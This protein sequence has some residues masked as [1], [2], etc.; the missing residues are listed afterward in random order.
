[1]SVEAY[2]ELPEAVERPRDHPYNCGFPTA[3]SR[4][5]SA[6]PRI[7]PAFQQLFGAIIV[8]AWALSRPGARDDRGC[9]GVGPDLLL[10]NDLSRRVSACRGGR[11]RAGGGDP[12]EPLGR[13]RP[14]AARV[15][16]A[17]S[18]TSSR[19]TRTTS[20]APT[21]T[22]CAC[23]VQRPR[24][25]RGRPRRRH[26]QPPHAPRGRLR[27]PGRRADADRRPRRRTT[28]A[29]GTGRTGLTGCAAAASRLMSPLDRAT[30]SSSSPGLRSRATVGAP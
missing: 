23:S 20:R 10:L 26:L 24:L 16:C 13:A 6:H 15:R 8:C 30:R 4:L 25:P 7:G 1:M 29:S 3:M 11:R 9:R 2:I 28:A 22:G 14:T 27:D 19:W 21:G 5:L 18:P 12:R 17:T